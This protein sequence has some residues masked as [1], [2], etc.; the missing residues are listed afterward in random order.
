MPSLKD[1]LTD[2]TTEELFEIYKIAKNEYGVDF[3]SDDFET[4]IQ[5]NSLK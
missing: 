4:K 3:F 2:S 1:S 5:Q